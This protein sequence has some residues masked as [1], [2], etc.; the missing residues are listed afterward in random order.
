VKGTSLFNVAKWF[1][2]KINLSL[3]FQE[4]KPCK[5]QFV[6]KYF[7]KKIPA[8]HC[9]LTEETRRGLLTKT[10]RSVQYSDNLASLLQSLHVK[11]GAYNR[12]LRRSS[13]NNL[14]FW[15][16]LR[17]VRTCIHWFMRLKPWSP[18]IINW[19]IFTAEHIWRLI[20]DC[21]VVCIVVQLYDLCV[22]DVGETSSSLVPNTY[23]FSCKALLLCNL[24]VSVV[25]V[26]TAKPT[27]WSVLSL[28]SF[29]LHITWSNLKDGLC[30]KY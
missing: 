15:K 19:Y 5:P 21:L 11:D 7:L 23:V 14:S 27:E 18:V 10:G 17:Q 8:E 28:H 12:K 29:S 13:C 3:I 24:L 25:V 4:N 1:C 20:V 26:G 30:V 6:L 16:F 2:L 9:L 22:C